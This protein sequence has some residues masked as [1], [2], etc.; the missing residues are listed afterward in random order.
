[1]ETIFVD[2]GMLSFITPAHDP[3]LVDLTVIN[4]DTLTDMR[5]GALFYVEDED[6][7]PTPEDEERL[8]EDEEEDSPKETPGGCSQTPLE[9]RSGLLGMMVLVGILYR[10]RKS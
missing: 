5:A 7:I 10:R 9:N 1:M 2:S 3:G 6:L 8:S 4:P